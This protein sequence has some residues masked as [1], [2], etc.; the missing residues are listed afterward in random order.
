MTRLF[1]NF[2]ILL[3]LLVH[4]FVVLGV[5]C[6]FYIFP[7]RSFFLGNYFTLFSFVEYPLS[8]EARSVPG[9]RPHCCR[10]VVNRYN[11]FQLG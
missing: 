7:R 2:T 3:A 4:A 10:Y 1:S 6:L 8:T 5:L 11:L 9:S